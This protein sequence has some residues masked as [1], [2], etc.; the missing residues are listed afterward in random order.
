MKNKYFFLSVMSIVL[1][2]TSLAQTYTFTSASVTGKIGPT[3]VEVDAA[4][5]ATTLDGDVTINTQG[6]QEWVVPA[7]GSYSIEAHGASGGSHATFSGHGVQLYGEMNLTMGTTLYILVGQ[8]GSQNAATNS[9]GGGGGT[10][11]SDGTNPL[12][13]AGG[14]GGAAQNTNGSQDGSLLTTV[15]NG[16][17][18]QFGSSGAGYTANGTHLTYGIYTTVAQSFLNNGGG[19]GGGQAS[20]WPGGTYGDGGFG[21]GGSACSCNTG[22]GGGGGGFV[23]GGGGGNGPYISG[24][25]GSSYNDVS[26]TNVT[27][28]VLPGTGDGQLIIT[29]LCVPLTTTVSASTIC[30][31]ES[32]I[33]SATSTGTGTITWDNGI[34]D[35]IAFTPALGGTTYTATSS[36]G[37]DCSFAALITVNDLPTVGAGAD[38][39][40]CDQAVDTALSGSGAVTYVWDNGVTNGVS[41]TPTA[42]NTTY[43][44]TG[45]DANGCENT[46]AVL[47]SVGGPVLTAS[48]THENS[49]SDGSIDLTVAGGSGS[50]TYSWSSGPFTQDITNLIAGNYTVLVNDGMCSSDSIFTVLNVAGVDSFDPA[51]FM[52]FPNPSSGV[53][54]ISTGQLFS[55]QI[56]NLMGKVIVEDNGTQTETVDLSDFSNGVYLVKVTVNGVAKTVKLVKH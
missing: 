56:M 17:A 6:I 38:I 43:S 49:G 3:Q 26:A 23:G 37:N 52:V 31:G 14:G 36:D 34:S 5:T 15:T 13:V 33:L 7:T 22:G 4:Y 39:I 8:M 54:T 30:L 9:D 35:G 27:S 50:Y 19:Q 41:F 51:S 44:V 42:G 16:N 28:A 55:Y 32:V 12:I 20:G 48:I 21:G 25:G 47:I 1:S 29:Q 40:L 45:T 11:V 18:S 24:Y 10:F 2:T 53:F 46:D